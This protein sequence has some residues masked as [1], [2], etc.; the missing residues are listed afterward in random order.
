ME[1]GHLVRHDL[2]EAIPFCQIAVG[3]RLWLGDKNLGTSISW[4]PCEHEHLNTSCIQC[5]GA[6]EWLSFCFVKQRW[7]W[8]IYSW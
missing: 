4:Q 5:E 2:P 3:T 1:L 8:M 7:K 6:P